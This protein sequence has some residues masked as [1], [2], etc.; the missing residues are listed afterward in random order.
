M[1]QGKLQYH[2]EEMNRTE[3]R[4]PFSANE[5]KSVRV[6]TDSNESWAIRVPHPQ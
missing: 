5:S 1:N 2:T 4:V 3:V 6:P